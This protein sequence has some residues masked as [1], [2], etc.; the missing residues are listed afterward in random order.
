[1]LFNCFNDMIEMTSLWK[2][3]RYEDGRPRVSDG[4]LE[5][6]RKLKLEEVWEPLWNKGYANQFEGEFQIIHRH[7]SMVGRAVTA[8][9]V[10][11]RPD[12]DSTLRTVGKENGF[13][14]NYNQWVIDS[15]R[16]DDVAVVD[17]FDKVRFGTYIGGNLGT[18]ISER[19]KR[20]GAVIWGGVRDSEQLSEI[21]E[22]N[23]FCRG[24]DPTLLKDTMMVGFNVPTR[25]GQAICLPG[26]VVLGT[27]AGVV[28]IPPHLA[29]EIA[30]DAEKIQIRDHFSF[31]R[32]NS[33]TYTTSELDAEWSSAIWSDFY[34]WLEVAP[35]AEQYRYLDWGNE[36]GILTS[37][38]AS[39]IFE[40][41]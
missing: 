37:I 16:D 3:E 13:R 26:D 7:K 15:L 41:K 40:Q 19:T 38:P 39:S 9:M 25:I 32:L 28:F 24:S 21:A 11:Q 4:V 6:I 29:E 22:I 17:L 34:N 30:S 35:V 10:P 18:S 27:P 12:L 5:R 36:K 2:G 31:E 20:G 8:V 23:V 14:G 33:R 1:M